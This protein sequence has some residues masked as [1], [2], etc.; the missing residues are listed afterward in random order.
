MSWGVNCDDPRLL[1]Y[2]HEPAVSQMASNK[3]HTLLITAGAFQLWEWIAVPFPFILY[4]HL[5]NTV[6]QKQLLA[7][8]LLLRIMLFVTGVNG[9]LTLTGD[10]QCWRANQISVCCLWLLL[11]SLSFTSSAWRWWPTALQPVTDCALCATCGA[12]SWRLCTRVL[13]NNCQFCCSL[14]ICS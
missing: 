3:N 14:F 12:C 9:K 7:R 5:A 4:M 6:R 10:V 2:F 13:C 8:N 1:A 11:I